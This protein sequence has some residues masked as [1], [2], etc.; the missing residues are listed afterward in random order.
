MAKVEACAGALGRSWKLSL[1]H[2]FLERTPECQGVFAGTQAV[3]APCASSVECASGLSCE[4]AANEQNR[5][6]VKPAEVVGAAC[7]NTIQPFASDHPDC[8]AGLSCDPPERLNRA[9]E[10]RLFGDLQPDPES[11]S[12]PDPWRQ[13]SS[14]V[15]ITGVDRGIEMGSLWTRVGTITFPGQGGLIPEP[16]G[17]IRKRTVVRMDEVAVDGKMAK[18]AVR[19]LFRTRRSWSLCYENWLDRGGQSKATAEVDFTIDPDGMIATATAKGSSPDDEHCLVRSILG[20]TFPRVEAA[21]NVKVFLSFERVE[22]PWDADLD[23][24]ICHE[25][26]SASLRFGDLQVNPRGEKP[27]RAGEACDGMDCAE[28]LYCSYASKRAPRCAPLRKA[29]SAC[30]SSLQCAGLCIDFKCAA[31]CGSH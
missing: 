27:H 2:P 16:P 28:G 30:A 8:R 11:G 19:R 17:K 24:P 31:F 14:Q 22:A 1:E 15:G 23:P 12:T 13:S 4:R 10:A 29:G 20:A 25:V 6:C 21:T 5:R 7:S 26:E 18:S 9:V 3:G